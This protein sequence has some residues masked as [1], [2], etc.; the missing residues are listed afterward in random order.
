LQINGDSQAVVSIANSTLLTVGTPWSANNSGVTYSTISPN[1]VS[2]LNDNL[3]QFA[4]FK[5]FQIKIILQSYSTAMVPLV[6]DVRAL[7]LQL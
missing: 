7:A 4:S 3:S 1:G 5:R 6:N 2:Y